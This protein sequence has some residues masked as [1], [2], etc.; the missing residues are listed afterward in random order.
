MEILSPAGSYEAAI[1]AVQSGADA[2]YL[3][4]GKFNAR[5]S[6]AN[7]DDASLKQ[8]VEYCHQR[9]VRV[10]L[11]LNTLLSDKELEQAEGLVRMCSD[12]GVDALIVQD[13]GVV[14][15]VRR[16]APELPIHGSTQMTVHNLDGVLACAALGMERVVLSRELSRRQIAYIC[17]RSP[18]E[19]EVFGHGALCMCYSGQCFL[20]SAIGGRSGNRGM[21][22]QPCR[23]KYG[24]E[25]SAD[26]YPLSLKDMALVEH[27]AELEQ[28]GVASLKIEGRMK[29]PEYVGIVTRIYSTV[30]H[31]GR[32]PTRQE[33]DD[34]TAAFSRQGFTDGYYQGK[35]GRAMFGIHEKAPL[36]EKLFAQ[37][38]VEY[39][40][41]HSRVPLTMQVRLAPICPL[42]VTVTD[43]E[44]R[45]VTAYG[46]IPEPARS[47]SVGEEELRR[48]LSR[49]G[50]TCYYIQRMDME[51]EPGMSL[52]LSALN[53][54]RRKV[55]DEL[56]VLRVRPPQ[57]KTAPLPPLVPVAGHG[58]SPCFT[59]SLRQPEQL[60]EGL[61]RQKP[62]VIYLSPENILARKALAQKAIEEGIELC[63]ALPR[64]L[65]DQERPT[66]DEQLEQVK[67]MGVKT[68]LAGELGA[69]GIAADHGLACRGDFGIGTYNSRTV[70]TLADMG[71]I[72][73]TASFEQRLAAVR[74]LSKPI[75]LELIVYGRLPLMITQNCIIK[76]HHGRCNCVNTNTLTDRTG[77][78]FPVLRAHGCRSEIFNSKTLYLADKRESWAHLGLWA[79]RLSFTTESPTACIDL[80]EH[81]RTGAGEAPGEY[82]RGLY[83]RGVE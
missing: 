30:L 49:T 80:L 7:F 41:E 14:D 71:L 9:G 60:T 39:N 42:R 18:I 28:M 37:T 23:M 64:I 66:L 27:L 12:I 74:D 48:Q 55:L 33:L 78:Q 15:M 2:I 76:N 44:G 63:A 51:V 79:A 83:F 1:A 69:I 25:G 22:A 73:A 53:S 8:V 11:T 57:R 19:I 58:D 36:P 75:D 3:G 68:A 45:S 59:L 17:K 52:P 50:G 26:G 81:Y 72:S 40:R 61:I 24:W 38:R 32:K 47:K 13:L 20:S 6:A 43:P 4:Y 21:C 16:V 70:H 82:T 62:A 56:N 67:E 29:R 65:F 46:P 35:P 77:A 31:Q 10:H 5:R 54:L 34:L